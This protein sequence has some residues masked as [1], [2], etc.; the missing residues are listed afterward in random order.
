MSKYGD[1]LVSI[2]TSK[3]A[4]D[5]RVDAIPFT[6]DDLIA[7]SNKLGFEPPKNLG[8]IVY[9]F[10][11][12]SD[13]PP[14]IESSAPD[15][16][17]WIIVGTG[18]AQ[19][20][21]IKSRQSNIY[22]NP[23]LISVRIPNNTPEILSLYSLSDE[24]SLLAKIRYN[25]ILDLFLGIVTYSMQN[26]LRT[27]VQDIGQIEIDELYI[28][29]NKIGQQFIMPVQAKVGNDKIGAVQ[30]YQDICYCKTVFPDLICVPIAVHY[31]NE[32][33][34]MFRL[35]LENWS[36]GIVEE[37]HYKLVPSTGID[38]DYIRSANTTAEPLLLE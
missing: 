14:E 25:K 19:Y 16:Y 11:Y 28:G 1:I 18:D 30:L 32:E 26:H 23:D 7:H 9:A 6:R 12:R 3:F 36:V 38:S 15:G 33:V 31:A 27:K 13:M 22:P 8:D 10:R 17:T 37:R 21:F 34:C 35:A 29:V 5:N 20:S 4:S 2:F 24:Q